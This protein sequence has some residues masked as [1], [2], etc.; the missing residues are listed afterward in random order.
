MDIPALGDVWYTAIMNST[1]E[2]SDV[3][4]LPERQSI[5]TSVCNGG[6]LGIRGSANFAPLTNFNFSDA[7]IPNFSGMLC[8][9]RFSS[10][11][12]E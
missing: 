5:D 9:T 3:R 10:P 8:D 4:N 1:D 6:L 11:S 2:V 12:R 7:Y